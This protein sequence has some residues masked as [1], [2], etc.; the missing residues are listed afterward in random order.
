MPLLTARDGRLQVQ[1]DPGPRMPIS[2]GAA[3][4]SG[5]YLCGGAPQAHHTKLRNAHAIRGMQIRRCPPFSHVAS[6][7]TFGYSTKTTQEKVTTAR[8]FM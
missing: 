1:G 2:A 4:R 3:P 8:S 7:L 6:R 5:C